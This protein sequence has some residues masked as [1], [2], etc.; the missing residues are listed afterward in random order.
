MTI[1]RP[2]LR[3]ISEKAGVSKATVDRVV[4]NRGGVQNHTRQHVLSVMA[5]L[6]GDGPAGDTHAAASLCLDFVVP[7]TG[8][9]FMTQLIADV[10]AQVRR[11]AGIDVRVHRLDGIGEDGV[12][13][14][15]DRLAGDSRAVGLIA[16][17]HP[18]V[19]AAVRSLSSGG[20]PV[21]TIA[22]DIRNVPR[23]AYVGVDNRAAGRLAGYLTGRL[24]ARRNGKAALILGAR[25]YHGHEEREMGFRSVLRERFSDF[26]I[27]AEREIHEDTDTAYVETRALLERH[28]DIDAIYCIGAGQPG[29]A[30]ALIDC[31]RASSV[32]FVGHG[33]SDDTRGCL[34]DGV[35]DVVIDEDTS[36]MATTAIDCLAAAAR[37][38][39]FAPIP[40]IRVQAIFSENLPAEQ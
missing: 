40:S 6:T 26:R 19:R 38:E 29:V 35:M 22:S 34:I 13:A 11:R 36:L 18:N 5:E 33:L 20:V 2:R 24:A 17:D 30:R 4:N 39:P 15:L 10:Q 1:R 32:V 21:A 23:A 14:T 12:V 8:N 16:L 9:A 7:D 37:R 28:D 3:D 27:V 31:G 25:A